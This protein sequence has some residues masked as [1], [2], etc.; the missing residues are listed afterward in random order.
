MIV[1]LYSILN[2]DNFSFNKLSEGFNPH[3]LL[4]FLQSIKTLKCCDN[5]ENMMVCEEHS[6]CRVC[7]EIINSVDSSPE[8]CYEG[9]KNTCRTEINVSFTRER[10][11][12][13]GISIPIIS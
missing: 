5:I 4:I 9:G 10:S 3:F 6:I 1:I 7:N 8:K 11:D 12:R 13:I 2:V